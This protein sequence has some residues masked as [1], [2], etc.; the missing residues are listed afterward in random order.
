MSGK[1]LSPRVAE[2]EGGWENNGTTEILKADEKCW[3]VFSI[4]NDRLFQ[5]RF[6]NVSKFA[7]LFSKY[8]VQL[9]MEKFCITCL[10]IE[11]TGSHLGSALLCVN[12]R[13]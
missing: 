2:S 13:V 6:R 1:F 7:F 3:V 10:T 4:T 12:D 9:D 11:V 5:Q 8:V